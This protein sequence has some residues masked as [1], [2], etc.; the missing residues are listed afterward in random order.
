VS[1]ETDAVITDHLRNFFRGH[2]AERTTW[3][4]GPMVDI[5]PRFHVWQFAPGPRTRLWTYCSVGGWAL[6][7]ANSGLIE[8]VLTADR[9][10]SR[11]AELVTMLV[12]YHRDQNLG[13]GHTLPIGQPWL[14]GSKCDCFLI[15]KPYPFGAELEVC[16]LGD[17][18]V[19]FLWGL[20]ITQAERAFVG[21]EGL[22]ALEVRF[23]GARVN[24]WNVGRASVV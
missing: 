21:T 19:H 10:T 15:S 12:H 13:V 2:P 9:Q 20:P 22:E 4:E 17:R 24:Y 11:M 6:A 23:E 14:P 7:P 1:E 3:M 16:T 5:Q 18:H 8:F